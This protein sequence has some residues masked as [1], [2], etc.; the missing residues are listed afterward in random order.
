MTPTILASLARLYALHYAVSTGCMNRLNSPLTIDLWRRRRAT[1]SSYSIR[2]V[3]L[4]NNGSAG[5]MGRHIPALYAVP[6]LPPT[7]R[8]TTN[9]DV[10]AR[11]RAFPYRDS[12]A[13]RLAYA[14]F[15][16]RQRTYARHT[17]PQHAVLPAYSA[18]RHL[19][20]MCL[21]RAWPAILLPEPATA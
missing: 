14:L 13:Q 7:T 20:S 5:R 6:V 11:F 18:M 10:S 21:R 19:F 16:T 2:D 1:T 15:Q 9:L 8:A 4:N 12:I 17:A 3:E